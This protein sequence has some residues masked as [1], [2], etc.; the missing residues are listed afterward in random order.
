MEGVII[1]NKVLLELLQQLHKTG[2]AAAL[3]VESGGLGNEHGRVTA[4]TGAEDSS[5]VELDGTRSFPISSIMA[6]NGVY[7]T[8]FSTC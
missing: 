2:G 7:R 3:F 1:N 5:M 4:I 8:G 6:V